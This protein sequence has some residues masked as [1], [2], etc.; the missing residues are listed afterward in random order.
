MEM[1]ALQSLVSRSAA[2]LPVGV[3]VDLFLEELLAEN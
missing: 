3:R 1:S 2:L